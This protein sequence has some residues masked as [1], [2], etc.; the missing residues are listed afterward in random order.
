VES[1]GLPEDLAGATVF[2]ATDD[3]KYIT[4]ISLAVDGRVPVQHRSGPVDTFPL[5]RFPKLD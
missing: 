4:G 2:L 5:S 1:L 3:A